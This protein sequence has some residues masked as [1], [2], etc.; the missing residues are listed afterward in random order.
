MVHDD[1]ERRGRCAA[2][3]VTGAAA[4]VLAAV[5]G[6]AA[7]T[8]ENRSSS[9]ALTQQPTASSAT[10]TIV[11]RD[12]FRLENW[13][14]FDPKPGG[15]DPDYSFAGNRLLLQAQLTAPRID[16]TLAAQH[17]GLIGLPDDA[18]GP[19]A[20]GTGPI[21]FGQ[22]GGRENPQ[23]LY[24]RYA[25][26]R[27]KAPNFTVQAGRMGYASGAE[28]PS[29]IG[30]IEA[31]KRSRLNERLVGEFGWSLYQR[32]FDGVRADV[33]QPTWR[34]TGFTFMPTQG[35]FAREAGTTMTDIVAA[36]ATVSSVPTEAMPRTQVQGFVLYYGDTRAVMGRPDNTG[37]VAPRA[38]VS[39]T[40][41][42]GT[43]LGAYPTDNG[44]ADLFFWMAAQRGDWYG[45]RHGAVALAAEAGYQWTSAP[46]ALWLR[47]GLSY[48]SG[49]DDAT[50]ADHGT[51]FPM[52]PTMRRYSMTAAYS[53]MNLRDVFVQAM[54]RPSPDLSLRIDV[55]GLALATEADRWYA[56]SGA[57]LGRGTFGY[58]SRPSSGST[59]LGTSVEFSATYT[60]DP[61][62]SVNGFL[63]HI[64][65]GDVVTGTFAGDR[66][67]F[68]YVETGIGL[69]GL[70]W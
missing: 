28:A 6:A 56:G 53:T 64:N 24:L 52:L 45:D 13:R 65:G 29:G 66:L 27:F 3:I 32:G 2:A 54:L 38:D 1:R 46:W 62:F 68:F 26:V 18:L 20:L 17:V 50:D 61:R 25:N 41:I 39:V 70:W 11:L 48:A 4:L 33:V 21:Y 22:G 14:F 10:W 67:W 16:V 59:G 43:V 34:L 35:G 55:H 8:R 40:T 23:K 31:V 60:I 69:D 12:T 15:G 9:G 30:K 42:G 37:L 44:E 19:G 5:T 51:F 36:G 7:Q 57:T 47:G 58:V 49:D 63:G